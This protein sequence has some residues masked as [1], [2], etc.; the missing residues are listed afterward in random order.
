[1]LIDLVKAMA[2]ASACAG[3]VV[4]Y[5]YCCVNFI[6]RCH[7]ELRILSSACLSQSIKALTQCDSVGCVEVPATTAVVAVLPSS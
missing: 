3:I 6:T 1:M 4:L 5:Q 2:A 7:C